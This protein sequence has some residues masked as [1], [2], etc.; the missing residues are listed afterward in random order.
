MPETGIDMQSIANQEQSKFIIEAKQMDY[1]DFF[2]YS[3]EL[4]EKY[5]QKIVGAG[6]ESFVIPKKGE[7]RAEGSHYGSVCRSA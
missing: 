7:G 2:Q 5:N 6:V 1:M 4:M 3:D